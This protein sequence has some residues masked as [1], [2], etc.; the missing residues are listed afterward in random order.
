MDSC[1]DGIT[2]C[3]N[4][5][6]GLK[7]GSWSL[8]SR[9]VR[10]YHANFLGSELLKGLKLE[11]LMQL[12]PELLIQKILVDLNYQSPDTLKCSQKVLQPKP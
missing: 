3:L 10:T 12:N 9:S 1:D 5:D 6:Q 8:K 4:L 11:A 2:V 7:P